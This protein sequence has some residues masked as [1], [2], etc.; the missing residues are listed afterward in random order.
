M[1]R[2]RLKVRAALNSRPPATKKVKSAELSYIAGTCLPK[3][4]RRR[5]LA[6]LEL[7]ASGPRNYAG[8]I[9]PLRDT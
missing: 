1:G 7:I 4:I 5:Q 6:L 3:A 8:G 9:S 2:P